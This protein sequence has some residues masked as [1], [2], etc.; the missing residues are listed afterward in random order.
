MSIFREKNTTTTRI[1]RENRSQMPRLMKVN[2][3]IN[4][5]HT[6]LC[7]KVA[8][9]AE[10]SFIFSIDYCLIYFDTGID[11]INMYLHLT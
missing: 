1:L 9:S 3:I 10:Q 5:H 2:K 7:T 4:I 8:S 6:S 11:F